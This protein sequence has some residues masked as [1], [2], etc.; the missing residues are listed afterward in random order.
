[1]FAATA[2][3]SA[4]NSGSIFIDICIALAIVYFYYRK[5]RL[6]STNHLIL[7]HEIYFVI[8]YR[9]YILV[10]KT[11]IIKNLGVEGRFFLKNLRII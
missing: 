1:V 8:S 5:W 7:F 10:H 9:V 11:G 3:N 4:C 2:M 6:D